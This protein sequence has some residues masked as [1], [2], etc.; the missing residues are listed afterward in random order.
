MLAREWLLRQ[1][2]MVEERAPGRATCCS[3]AP[4]AY[5]RRSWLGRGEVNRR[6]R[7][8][9]CQ[10]VHWQGQGGACGGELVVLEDVEVVAG[11]VDIDSLM[12]PVLA[13]SLCAANL[14][15]SSTMP[16]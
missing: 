13:S 5:Q 7:E 1:V 8:G 2:A 10:A 16:L 12:K 9:H 4:P 3:L 15:S 11:R 14:S 6:E